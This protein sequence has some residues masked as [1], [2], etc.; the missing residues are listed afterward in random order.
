[1][2]TDLCIRQK[3]AALHLRRP[4][5]IIKSLCSTHASL[6]YFLSALLCL[7]G[8]IQVQ[9]F[10]SIVNSPFGFAKDKKIMRRPRYLRH[11][12]NPRQFTPLENIATNFQ[13]IGCSIRISHGGCT[14]RFATNDPQNFVCK[15]TLKAMGEDLNFSSSPSTPIYT[16]Q[17]TNNVQSPPVEIDHQNTEKIDEE[18]KLQHG[19]YELQYKKLFSL[20]VPEGK[21]VGLKLLNLDLAPSVPTSL[22]SKQIQSNENHWLRSILHPDEI[23]YGSDISLNHQRITFFVGRL[24]M[25]TVLEE[26]KNVGIDIDSR[27]SVQCEDEDIGAFTRTETTSL[28]NVSITD[29]SILKDEYGRPKVPHGFIGS[30]SHKKTTGVAL[31]CELSDSESEAQARGISPTKGIGVDIE[32]ASWKKGKRSIAKRVLTPSEIEDLGS[33]DGVSREEEVLLRFSLK[34]SVYKAM[35]PLI[36]HYVGFQEAEI[37]PLNDGTALVSLDLKSGQHHRFGEV[38][39]HWRRISAS[40]SHKT[41][42][43]GDKNHDDD[44]F[45]ST[46]RVTLKE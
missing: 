21:C 38:T 27:A 43:E 20:D 9:S 10:T 6:K 26:M 37:K 18:K 2:P 24:A 42:E 30:I 32:Q 7:A 31:A 15:D 33:L 29:Q 40:D 5:P 36:C 19:T 25:R 8:I 12:Y 41:M 23:A 34:E 11:V 4:S 17:S 14:R 1:M 28:P 16:Q 45:L 46:S 13:R 35:H 3:L 44:Y 22:D 39:A